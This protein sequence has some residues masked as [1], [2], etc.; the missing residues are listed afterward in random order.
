MARLEQDHANLRAALE[1][2][3]ATHDAPLTLRLCGA[4]IWFWHF[5]GYFSETRAQLESV[6]Q[7][8]TAADLPADPAVIASL[9][10]VEW[11]A[12]LFA[13][14]QG[15]FLA[16]RA[17]FETSVRLF[18]Q[19]LQPDGLAHALSNLGLVAL[20][21]GNLAEAHALT[22]EAVALARAGGLAWT[23]A[24]MLYNAGAVI[25]AHGHEAAAQHLLQESQ[26]RF[27]R[28]GDQWGQSIS[29]VHLGLMAARQGDYPRAQALVLEALTMQRAEDDVW[30]SVAALALLGQIAQRQGDSEAAL[31]FYEECVTRLYASV[32]DQ[33]TLAV[34]LHGLGTLAQEHGRPLIAAQ[35]LSAALATLTMAGGT[36]HLS[37]TSRAELE[38]AVAA[39]RAAFGEAAFA[40]AG[41]PLTIE[42]VLALTQAVSGP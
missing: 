1:W 26:A 41:Q 7:N 22:T 40:A 14:G 8:L 21:V 13:W 32:G 16:A 38:Q 37:L 5:R 2:S 9:A 39:V 27:Q 33:A 29:I 34:A 12:G 28:L 20:D 23:L 35:L 25:D 10:K 18:R 19:L 36:T 24:L 3:R 11:G 15:D 30:G 17:R 6:L 31:A 42:Q 4:L